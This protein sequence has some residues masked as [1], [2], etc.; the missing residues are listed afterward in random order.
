MA[1]IKIDRIIKNNKKHYLPWNYRG[2]LNLKIGEYKQALED[3]KKSLSL[4]TNFAL[5]FNNVALCYQAL[6]DI[7]YAIEFYGR[8][9]SL[10]PTML[11]AKVNLGS[12]YLDSNKFSEAITI[13][14]I[15][16][17]INPLHEHTHQL[18]ADAYIKIAKFDL[19][20][21]HHFKARDINPTNYFNYYLLG[22][23]YL[24]SGHKE[25]ASSNFLK[26]IELN[27]K[28]CQSYYGLS[29]V[30]KINPEE[31]ILSDISK[32]LHDESINKS[33]RVYLNF[34]MA[35][36]YEGIDSNLFFKYLDEE[37]KLKKEINGF[38]FES[39]QA[40]SD[41]SIDL[42]LNHVSKINQ[43]PESANESIDML[44]PIFI[45]GMPRSGTSLLEQVFSNDPRIFGAGEIDLFHS[46][47][48]KIMSSENPSSDITNQLMELRY[49]YLS[50]IRS[51]TDKKFFTDKLPLNFHWLGFIKKVFPNAKIIHIERNP[52]ATC[53]SIY[54][55]LFAHGSLDFSYSQDDIVSFY[56]LYRN[57]MSFWSSHLSNF[58]FHANY[59]KIVKNPKD[60][61][62]LIFDYL[63]LSFS[64]EILE[65]QMNKRSV[66]TASDLQVREAI[67]D[68]S[69]HSWVKYEDH[70]QKFIQA[71]IG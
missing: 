18:I 50:N 52:V 1:F 35:K 9:S 63:G 68:G 54:K 64:E 5:G 23:D 10:D 66:L 37:N 69:S 24:W 58:I 33:D 67:Y 51:M 55:T 26:A 14:N 47:L 4:N 44:T 60:E 2:I 21:S 31:P 70:I 38:S 36:V 46:T 56:K 41:K 13:L 15:A 19:S 45:V 6:G 27:P 61:F 7:K 39:F 17:G 20:L 49:N 43:L 3:F 11:E 59:E 65:V 53:F 34:S 71:F 29:R 62:S 25:E 40:L 32:L 42:F 22:S 8:A 28:Y 12:L 16:L 57:L 30:M 48:I